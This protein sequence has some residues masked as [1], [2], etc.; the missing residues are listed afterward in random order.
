[1]KKHDE[2]KQGIAKSDSSRHYVKERKAKPKGMT[3]IIGNA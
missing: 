3:N 2:K 1:M